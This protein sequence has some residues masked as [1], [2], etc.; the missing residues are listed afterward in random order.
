MN[1]ESSP[2]LLTDLLPDHLPNSYPTFGNSRPPQPTPAQ[3]NTSQGPSGC[4]QT[5]AR[6]APDSRGRG[7]YSNHAPS[8]GVD[9]TRQVSNLP[10]ESLLSQSLK[11]DEC[12]AIR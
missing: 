2:F 6:D 7:E 5:R 4:R 12:R 8:G 1:L 10:G 3:P 9:S 11:K